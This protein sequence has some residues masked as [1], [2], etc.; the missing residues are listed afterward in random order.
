MPLVPNETELRKLAT[1]TFLQLNKAIIADDINLFYDKIAEAWKQQITSEK[2]ATTFQEFF[3][4]KVDFSD[5]GN[6]NPVFEPPPSLNENA[7]LLLNGKFV[8]GE[9]RLSFRLQYLL[10]GKNWKLIGLHMQIGKIEPEKND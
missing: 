10:E 4:N 8:H 1:E 7:I 2:L 5:L 9:A 6:L 3:K